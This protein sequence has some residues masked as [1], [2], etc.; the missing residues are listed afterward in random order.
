M[1]KRFRVLIFFFYMIRQPFIS[2]LQPHSSHNMWNDTK[3]QGT[4]EA[5]FLLRT[6]PRVRQ[7]PGMNLCFLSVL[8]A[9]AAAGW[10][11]AVRGMGSSMVW[12][13][14]RLVLVV[15]SLPIIHPGKGLL[16]EICSPALPLRADLA[17]RMAASAGPVLYYCALQYPSFK[18]LQ[19]E[20]EAKAPPLFLPSLHNPF[21]P[22]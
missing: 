4:T 9:V 13:C 7:P 3:A 18:N 8:A 6:V 2:L 17:E 5:A 11:R 10:S 19:T 1:Y 16:K 20:K 21:L 22:R 15:E 12:A 14:P